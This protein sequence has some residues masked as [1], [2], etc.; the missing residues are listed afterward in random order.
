MIAVDTNVLVR[1][2]T[3]DEISQATA[4]RS[5]FTS[6]SVWIAKTVLLETD[7]VL[8]SLYGYEHSAVRDAFAGVLGL[9]NVQA[10]DEASVAEAL[11]LAQH[12]M[13]FADAI[14]LSSRPAGAAFVSFDK[15]LIRRARRA[16]VRGVS[17]V[18]I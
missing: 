18:P 16:G 17:P 15:T 10:E 12:G 14:H 5:L 4:A 3:G 1:L 2:L 11:A 7:W 9:D 13:Q 8:R 6:E